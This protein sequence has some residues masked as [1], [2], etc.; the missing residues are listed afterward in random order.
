MKDVFTYIGIIALSLFSFYY[1]DKVVNIFKGND[2]IMLEIMEA[3]ENYNIPCFEGS[4][5]EE[6]IVL[7]VKGKKVNKIESYNNMKAIGYDD[8][9]LVFEEVQCNI[10][11]DNNLNKY[12]LS[13][14]PSKNAISIIIKVNEGN[15]DEYNNL[16]L[17]KGVKFS[18]LIDDKTLNKYKEKLIF[19]NNEI[20]YGGSSSKKLKEYIKFMKNNNMSSYCV[21]LDKDNLELCSKENINV[22]KT[23]NY[24]MNKVYVKMKE[25]IKSGE[26]IIVEDKINNIEELRIMINYLSNKG[27]KILTINEH[28]M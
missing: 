17:E 28:L 4:I 20:L 22:I 5:S 3:E 26:F 13:G 16:S 25:V 12:I 15:I 24:F 6:G 8:S 2:P 14:N 18:Y 23:D 9:L 21:S 1:T 10:T 27:F 11:K 7:G 19:N